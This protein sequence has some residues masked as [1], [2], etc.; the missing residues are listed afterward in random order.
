MAQ[1][2]DDVTICNRALARL[3][4]GQIVSLDEDTDLA[5]Q[6]VAVYDDLLEAALTLY[7]WKWPRRTKALDRLDEV[8]ENGYLYGYGFP[9][10]AISNPIKVLADPRNPDYPLR[11]FVVEGRTLYTNA[12]A[13]WGAFV[14]RLSPD[15]WPP[16]FRL[17]FQTWLSAALAIPVSQDANLAAQ[18]EQQAIGAPSEQGRG[19]IMGRAI[20]I[21]GATSGGD[22]PALAS[23]PLTSARYEGAPWYGNF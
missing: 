23:D 15:L 3:G 4:G 16:V 20:A 6:C 7:H 17:A 5:R 10:G 13:V 1:T 18:L 21:D 8:P 22:A 9:A 19:G 2:I 11:E 12:I 14:F